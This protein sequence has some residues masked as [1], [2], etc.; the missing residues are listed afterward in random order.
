[1]SHDILAD[2]ICDVTC[3]VTCET[4]N[5]SVILFIWGNLM[6]SLYWLDWYVTCHM[7]DD[8]ICDVTRFV[9]H[10]MWHVKPKMWVSNWIFTWGNLMLSFFWLDWYLTSHILD[11]SIFYVTRYVTCEMWHMKPKCECQT[12]FLMGELNAFTFL[13]WLICHMPYQRWTYMLWHAHVTCDMDGKNEF[14]YVVIECMYC[15]D[16][17]DI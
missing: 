12:E 9:T 10:D 8:S 1:M 3:Y 15:S 14:V 16:L 5:V 6:L 7:L 2:S 17:I 4:Q 13:T 11:D